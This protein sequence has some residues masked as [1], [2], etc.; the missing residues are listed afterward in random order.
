MVKVP[1]SCRRL[2]SRRRLERFQASNL[3]D[4]DGWVVKDALTSTHG[5]GLV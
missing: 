4:D 1:D 2:A 3:G 5:Y